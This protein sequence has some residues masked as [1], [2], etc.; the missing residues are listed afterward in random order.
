MARGEAPIGCAL[1]RGDGTLIASGY[2]QQ[3]RTQN[4][5]AHAEIVTFTAAAGKADL[6][7]RDLIMSAT[8]E[9][10]VMCTGAAMEAAVDTIVY[11]LPAPADAGSQRVA[12]PQSPES[13]I[14]RF[15]GGILSD[16][17]RELFKQFLKSDP[18]PEQAAFVKQL[19]N[20]TAD[21]RG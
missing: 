11:A 4:K 14:P 12:C 10:C 21:N 1:F 17:S 2:N 6:G 15:V 5:V 20:V 9:P 7:A 13:Q 3:N 18:R 8:L 19:L 16:E